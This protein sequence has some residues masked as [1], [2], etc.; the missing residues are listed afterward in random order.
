MSTG[1]E[2]KPVTFHGAMSPNVSP[3]CTTLPVRLTI[4]RFVAASPANPPEIT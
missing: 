2:P 3:S 4:T 1:P